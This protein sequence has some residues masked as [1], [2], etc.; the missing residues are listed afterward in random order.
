[1]D[2]L[3]KMS[4]VPN[5]KSFEPLQSLWPVWA[6]KLKFINVCLF[7]FLFVC[8]RECFVTIPK[9]YVNVFNET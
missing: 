3:N 8:V 1:M 5:T 7:D 6:C 4:L 9:L 2:E